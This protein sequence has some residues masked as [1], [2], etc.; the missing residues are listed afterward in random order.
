M[1][2]PNPR[3]Q[4]VPV[5]D[6]HVV[7]VI[8][9]ALVEPD[10]LV[11]LAAKHWSAAENA[12]HN[13][14]PGPELHLPRS[15]DA[16]L[17]EFFLLTV[18]TPL[19]ARRILRSYSRLAMVTMAPHELAPRQWIAHRDRFDVPPGQCI[20]ASVLYLFR[21]E[22]LGGTSFFAPRRPAAE[23]DRL[24][25]ESGTDD[26]DAF[27]R[28]SGVEPGYQTQTNYWFEKIATIPPK[29]NR[30]IFYDG[31]LFHCADIRAPEKLTND[32]STGRLTFNGFFTCSR[33]L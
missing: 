33:A 8:D 7:Y 30:M 22:A 25:H 2:N 12:A 21:D 3:V 6:Q 13:A 11:A 31:A 19:G 32:P 20:G 15:I 4:T 28:K 24:V 27:A 16:K 18:R 10:K 17:D 1:F 26:R 23:I 5:T 14:Y 9:D 29:F